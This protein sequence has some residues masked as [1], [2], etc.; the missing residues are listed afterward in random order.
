MDSYNILPS[1]TPNGTVKISNSIFSHLPDLD[2]RT[3]PR[4][5]NGKLLLSIALSV[6]APVIAEFLT[7]LCITHVV[8]TSLNAYRPKMVEICLLYNV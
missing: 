5:W 3:T 7:F 6:D 8:I 2:F 4:S 1:I